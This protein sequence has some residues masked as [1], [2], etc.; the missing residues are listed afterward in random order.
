MSYHS[1]LGERGHLSEQPLKSSQ[2]S[3]SSVSYIVGLAKYL[4]NTIPIIN[5]SLELL[6]E[7][8]SKKKKKTLSLPRVPRH[9]TDMTKELV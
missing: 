4:T 8:F 2:G 7:R 5:S 1:I 6:F 9:R 3:R